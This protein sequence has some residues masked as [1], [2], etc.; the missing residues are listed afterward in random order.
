MIDG[1]T[2]SDYPIKND[3]TTYETLE[4]LLLIKEM[5]TQLVAY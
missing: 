5:I 1:K 2:F 4:K 3:K